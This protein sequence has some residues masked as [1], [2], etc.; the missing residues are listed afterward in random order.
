[1]SQAG[2]GDVDPVT[3]GRRDVDPA[4]RAAVTGSSGVNGLMTTL[5]IRSSYILA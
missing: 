5:Q 1:M 4:A 3:S 2:R